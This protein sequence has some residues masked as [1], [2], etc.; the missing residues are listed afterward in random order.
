MAD[1]WVPPSREDPPASSPRGQTLQGVLALLLSL[2][3][4]TFGFLGLT[5]HGCAFIADRTSGCLLDLL[6]TCSAL[7]FA[8]SLPLM[9][10]SFLRPRPLGAPEDSHETQIRVTESPS[11]HQLSPDVFDGLLTASSKC[12]VRQGTDAA[13]GALS[14]RRN[15]TWTHRPTSPGEDLFR[16]HANSRPAKSARSVCDVYARTGGRQRSVKLGETM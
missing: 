2:A 3:Q 10:R 7:A 13:S 11:P 14:A 4:M 6:T 1:R 12:K 16:G 8:F 9:T 15:S 5:L